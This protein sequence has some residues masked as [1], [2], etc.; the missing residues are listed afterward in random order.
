[1]LYKSALLK[2]RKLAY[3]SEETLPDGT[4]NSYSRT[5]LD[6]YPE[7]DREELGMPDSKT[8]K[9]IVRAI[10]DFR[11]NASSGYYTDLELDKKPVK[12]EVYLSR[13]PYGIDE[14]TGKRDEIELGAWMDRYEHAGTPEELLEASNYPY[15][16]Q[17]VKPV[18]KRSLLR[19]ILGLKPE[20]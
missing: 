10:K 12:A 3:G 13:H 9:E 2:M 19:R 17:T 20:Y 7:E 5:Y 15:M 14:S 8:V 6:I 16:R 11:D 18:K 4:I 1:M